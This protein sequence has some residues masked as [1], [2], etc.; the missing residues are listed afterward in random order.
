[1]LILLQSFRIIALE[2]ACSS[3]GRAPALQAGGRGF[4]SRHVHQP[5]SF[6]ENSTGVRPDYHLLL[7]KGVAGTNPPLLLFTSL[8]IT[9]HFRSP[10]P[11]HF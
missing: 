6:Q 10:I 1:M 7:R 9:L 3:V 11:P 4:E 5:F 8:R 2:W